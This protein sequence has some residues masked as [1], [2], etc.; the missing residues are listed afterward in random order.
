MNESIERIQSGREKLKLLESE[1]KYVFHGSENPYLDS[2]EPRQAYTM[3]DGKKVEDDKPAV[4]ASQFSDIAIFM[5]LINKHNCPK[6][7]DN[8]FRYVEGQGV[9]FSVTQESLDQ[10]DENTRGFVYV[11]PKEDFIARGRA[12]L[13][14][15]DTVTPFQM[16]EVTKHDLSDTIEIK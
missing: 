8:G 6:G 12:Q 16:I 2:L 10:L 1:D 3:E 14:T 11:F 9:K 15:Y 5:A 4:H 7:F 13:I